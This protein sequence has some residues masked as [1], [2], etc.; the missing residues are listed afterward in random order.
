VTSVSDVP[1]YSDNELRAAVA[2]A[3]AA[4]RERIRRLAID[5]NALYLAGG[6]PDDAEPSGLMPFADLIGEQP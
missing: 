5:R 3:V 6:V 2:R 1:M 4:E